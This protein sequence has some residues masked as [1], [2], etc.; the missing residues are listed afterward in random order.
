VIRASVTAP[1]LVRQAGLR[2]VVVFDILPAVIAALACSIGVSHKAEAGGLPDQLRWPA[3]VATAFV[4]GVMFL[5]RRRYPL[6]A[7]LGTVALTVVDLE[8]TLITF[9]VF[10]LALYTLAAYGRSWRVLVAVVVLAVLAVAYVTPTAMLDTLLTQG[11]SKESLPVLRGFLLTLGYNLAPVAISV[12]LGLYVITRRHLITNLREKAEQL[13]REQAL[14]AQRAQIAREMHDVVAHNVSLMVVHAGGVE[15]IATQDP[16]AA[17]NSARML[18]DIGRQALDELRQ[19]LGVLRL[20][21]ETDDR[22]RQP[23]LEGMTTLVEQSRMAG[24][25]ITFTT[26]GESRSVE[27]I[28]ERTAYRVVQEALTNVHKHAGRVRTK[29]LL[30]YRPRALNVVVENAGPQRPPPTVLPSGGHGLAGMR[31]RITILGGTFSAGPTEDGGF[32]V[33]ATIPCKGALA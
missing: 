7:A 19:I 33:A 10:P 4:V 24:M 8:S 16:A 3:V 17:A 11:L 18:G 2:S 14:L 27:E 5:R 32:R 15:M 13:E 28:V 12:L 31:E 21:G 20:G 23:T 9:F 6:I 30:H 26:H 25:E 29:V 22:M 1:Q